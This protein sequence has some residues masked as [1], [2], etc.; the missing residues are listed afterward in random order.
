MLLVATTEVHK[1]RVEAQRVTLVDEDGRFLV[2][3]Q[4]WWL[5]VCSSATNSQSNANRCSI[6]VSTSDVHERMTQVAATGGSTGHR[7][8]SWMRGGREAARPLCFARVLALPS[9]RQPTTSR[10]RAELRAALAVYH[11]LL[12]ATNTAAEL[13]ILLGS[14]HWCI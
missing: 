12:G 14:Y 5:P 8:S 10:V 4:L 13:R 2:V 1:A 11:C 6:A 3:D 7:W 9:Y